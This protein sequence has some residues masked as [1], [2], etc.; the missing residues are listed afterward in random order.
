M[1]FKDDALQAMLNN[2][3]QL[4]KPREHVATETE[5]TQVLWTVRYMVADK[6]NVWHLMAL[7]ERENLEKD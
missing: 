7:A 5:L 4:S 6:A 2:S 3:D 1:R